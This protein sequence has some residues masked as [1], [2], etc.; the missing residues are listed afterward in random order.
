MRF[1]CRKDRLLDPVCVWPVHVGWMK[2]WCIV[3]R[4]L[5]NIPDTSESQL[6]S[7]WVRTLCKAISSMKCP[8]TFRCN[9]AYCSP[10]ATSRITGNRVAF[11]FF[12]FIS[13]RPGL[14]IWLQI[15][16]KANLLD[17]VLF[18]EGDKSSAVICKPSPDTTDHCSSTQVDVDP[19]VVMGGSVRATSWANFLVKWD[20]KA[21]TKW[22]DPGKVTFRSPPLNSMHLV[23]KIRKITTIYIV[24]LN[25]I[26]LILA[27]KFPCLNTNNEQCYVHLKPWHEAWPKFKWLHFKNRYWRWC[28]QIPCHTQV[29]QAGINNCIP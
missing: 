27:L 9:D 24:I 23:D 8:C 5:L 19:V 20:T 15:W 21:T 3:D 29:S 6:S 11:S 13:M 17:N 14:D 28:L 18:N 12:I 26:F 4:Y 10:L 25:S 2:W 22:N 1:I 7:A 16:C